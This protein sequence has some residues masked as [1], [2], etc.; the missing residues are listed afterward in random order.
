MWF[1]FSERMAEKTVAGSQCWDGGQ[2]NNRNTAASSW[3]WREQISVIDGTP[4]R[5][6]CLRKKKNR[7]LLDYSFARMPDWNFKPH[8]LFWSSGF[9]ILIEMKRSGLCALQFHKAWARC[10]NCRIHSWQVQSLTSMS[11]SH[12]LMKRN[13]T[14]CMNGRTGIRIRSSCQHRAWG[15]YLRIKRIH[16]LKCLYCAYSIPSLAKSRDAH[17]WQPINTTAGTHMYLIVRGRYE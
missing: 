4:Y 1:F 6:D 14:L 10:Q 2:E 5:R 17:Q 7:R 9:S 13:S 15:I 12:I 11:F 16:C 8:S 3:I